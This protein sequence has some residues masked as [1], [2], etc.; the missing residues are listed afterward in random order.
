MDYCMKRKL[1]KSQFLLVIVICS[2]LIPT[3]SNYLVSDDLVDA[4]FLSL[5]LQFECFDQENVLCAEQQKVS[6]LLGSDGF[7][8]A[9]C[10]N[11]YT[12]NEFSIFSL[13]RPCT[14]KK[15]PILRC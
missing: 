7:F 9:F 5:T 2:F 1:R 11:K 10:Q 6:V 8:L 15:I 14:T 12:L 4:D 13:Q 3:L